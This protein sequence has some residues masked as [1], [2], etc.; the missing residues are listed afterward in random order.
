MKPCKAVGCQQTMPHDHSG[1]F[2]SS[3]NRIRVSCTGDLYAC[4]GKEGAID[5]IRPEMEDVQVEF[6]ALMAM[7]PIP[8]PVSQTQTET[9][10]RQ[11]L[12]S[13]LDQLGAM[14]EQNDYGA[15]TLFERHGP[16]LCQALGEPGEE[17]GRLIKR[18]AFDEALQKLA[19]LR[20]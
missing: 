9:M 15:V 20:N 13:I 3:C 12:R 2:C 11:E 8:Q 10:P 6:G 5:S 14:L 17:L 18:F 16:A 19:A 1:D 7:L 4:M